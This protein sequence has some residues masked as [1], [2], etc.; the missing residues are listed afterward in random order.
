MRRGVLG[1]QVVHVARADDRQAGLGGQRQEA[2]VDALVL[3]DAG[4]LQLD[5]DVLAPEDLHEAVELLARTGLIARQQRRARAPGEAAGQRDDA[6]GVGLEQLVVDARLVVVALEVAERAE[7]DEVVVAG[8]RLGQQRQVVPVAL[9]GVHA[10]AAVVD[11]VDLTAQQ[12]LDAG[13]AGRAIELDRARHGAVV[14]DADGGHAELHRALDELRDA[15]GAVQHRVLGMDVQ[16]GVTRHGRSHRRHILGGPAT[17]MASPASFTSPEARRAGRAAGSTSCQRP[18]S[19]RFSKRPKTARAGVAT[20]G[21][22]TARRTSTPTATSFVT[23]QIMR[24]PRRS[25]AS[26]RLARDA[27][28]RARSRRRSRGRARRRA[29]PAAPCAAPRRARR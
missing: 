14:G 21:F 19:R 1:A 5:V 23:R 25:R 15:A 26:E 27:A 28:C 17:G 2:G 10:R 12:R 29:R 20:F 7:L 4:V 22:C 3:V 6:V 24:P 18:A 8:R 16:V 13:L 11:E 9:V